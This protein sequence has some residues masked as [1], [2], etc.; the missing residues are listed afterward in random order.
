MLLFHHCSCERKL[1]KNIAKI[2]LDTL[3]RVGDDYCVV[4]IV[5]QHSLMKLRHSDIHLSRIAIMEPNA[6]IK[7]DYQRVKTYKANRAC[8][9]QDWA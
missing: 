7:T 3:S 5:G 4:V 2:I 1:V 9:V 8:V 6:T